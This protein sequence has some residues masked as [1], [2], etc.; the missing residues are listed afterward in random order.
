MMPWSLI[1][2]TAV[3]ELLLTSNVLMLPLNLL[4]IVFAHRTDKPPNRGWIMI[5]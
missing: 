2:G 1:R 3:V 4:C 5:L